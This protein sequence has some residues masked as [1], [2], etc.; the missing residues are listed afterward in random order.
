MIQDLRKEMQQIAE[1]KGMH[2]KTV[3]DMSQKLDKL[4]NKYEKLI[5]KNE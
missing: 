5:N 2:D 1:E 3:L 4:L